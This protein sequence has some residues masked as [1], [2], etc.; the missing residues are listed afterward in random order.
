MVTSTVPVT[1]CD[2]MLPL[3]EARPDPRPRGAVIVIQEAFGLTDHIKE[4]ADRLATLGYLAVAP[5]LF[6]RTGDPVVSYDDIPAVY[7]HMNALDPDGLNTDLDATFAYIRNGGVPEEQIGSVGFCM[8][9][10]LSFYVATRLPLGASVSF[11]GGGIRQGRFGLPS[12]LELTPELQAP[13]LGF[14]GDLDGGIPTEE[15]EELRAATARASVPTELV[16]YPHAGHGFNC[17]MRESFHAASARDAWSR[18]TAWFE[19]H[20]SA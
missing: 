17:D 10:S 3:Y 6:H 12:L 13:W 8:G 7:Q 18:T 2:G 15:V 1:I 5:H 20:L 9:G 19:Q 14:F 11:Y 4:I 16:R